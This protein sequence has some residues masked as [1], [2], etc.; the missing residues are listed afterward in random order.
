MKGAPA[1]PGSFQRFDYGIAAFAFVARSRRGAHF[2]R[3][4]DRLGIVQSA[5]SWQIQ[6]LEIELQAQ[7]FKRTPR[8]V[9]LTDAGREF[10]ENIGPAIQPIEEAAAGATNLRRPPS[11]V[12]DD[13]FAPT[14]DSGEFEIF[15]VCTREL[16]TEREPGRPKPCR[17]RNRW[18]TE[19]CPGSTE[20]GV[21][22]I[23]QSCRSLAES[24][25]T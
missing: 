5:L 25:N 1:S 24:G 20:G 4:A 3:A 8:A 2:G 22:R 12:T 7:L 6:Q 10:V 21:A 17:E 14:G 19:K 13:P 11:F 23:A 18:Q 15:T 16:Y 9:Q